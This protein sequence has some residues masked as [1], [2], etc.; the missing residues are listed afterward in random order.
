MNRIKLIL[1]SIAALFV[2]GLRDSLCT[3]NVNDRGV[4]PGDRPKNEMVELLAK[5][6]G[7]DPED[8]YWR[9]SRGLSPKQ[10]VDVAA[11]EA[12]ERQVDDFAEKNNSKDDDAIR[13]LAKERKIENTQ[14]MSRQQLL[15]AI[16]RADNA[17][18]GKPAPGEASPPTAE[19]ETPPPAKKSKAAKK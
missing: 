19:P 16:V 6:A 10:A 2:G 5:G 7:V 15:I 17:A 13:A 18:A 9:V 11:Q 1:I 14:D 12:L 8:V 3:A 4:S